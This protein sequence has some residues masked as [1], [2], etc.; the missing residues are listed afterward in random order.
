MQQIELKIETIEGIVKEKKYYDENSGYHIL[1][2][3]LPSNKKIIVTGKSPISVKI[4]DCIS[5]E[6]S[7][8][9]G[10][11][12]RQF[13]TKLID[14]IKPTKLATIKSYLTSGIIKG[15]TK[16]NA[17]ELINAW[18]EHSIEVID[19]HPER[20]L[21]LKGIGESKLQKIIDSWEDIKPTEQNV[22]ELMSYGF[23]EVESIKIIQKFG[24]DSIRILKETPY[25]IHK[26]IGYIEFEKVD[27]VALDMGEEKNSP[28]R[29]QAAIDYFLLKGHEG[30]ECIV[31]YLFF[32]SR[33]LRYLKID[34]EYLTEQID[35][36][37]A[38]QYFFDYEK[39]E[40]DYE[41]STDEE[42]VFIV[43][44]YIQHKKIK[45][46]ELEVSRRLYM[47]LN[48]TAHK[49]TPETV[50]KIKKL[51]RKGEKS[52]PLSEE[53]G[54]AVLKSIN[55]KVSIITGGPG[56]GKTTVL[57]DVLKQLRALGKSVY[58]CAPTGKAAQRMKESTGFA[59][60][61]IHRLL[62]F[63]PR[64]MR[65]RVNE[66]NPLETDVIVIDESS[67]I[68]IFLMMHL[69][70]AINNDTQIVIVGDVNQLASVQAGAV[71][72]D[73]ID[74][75][76]VATSSL[77]QI[78]RQAAESKIVT[79]AH[80]INKGVFD[81]SY[82]A[83][84]DEDFY[85]MNSY[86]DENTLKKMK[87]IINSK[88]SSKFKLNPKNDLQ[89]LVPQHKGVLGTLNLNKEMQTMLNETIS[90]NV[91]TENFLYK[92]ND[93]I[94]QIVNNYDKN[95]FNG[96][97]GT[98]TI[99]NERGVSVKFDNIVEEVEY[100]IKELEEISPSYCL[101]I[102]KSQGSEY[103]VVIIP[104]PQEYNGIIDRSLI[105]TGITRGKKLVVIIGN[106]DVLKKGIDSQSSRF[107]KTNLKETIVELFEANDLSE[108]I[109]E[110]EGIH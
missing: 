98:I 17:I 33:T 50:F 82:K 66:S 57:N 26:R 16:K 18:G 72:R 20:L 109:I 81:F 67:M 100:E 65:F 48:N 35:E 99:I 87:S 84:A 90:K 8:F 107:R 61:T 41:F 89:L 83:G 64:D 19:K 92:E 29:I 59:A 93:K 38:K 25:I 105:Y 24:E 45:N 97:C 28:A 43:T 22:H 101:S 52:F 46:A 3:L 60:S 68:D 37:L 95:V 73:F 88:I 23:D 13:G 75:G 39:K 42:Y 54:K 103:P 27:E 69:L 31:N 77:T 85:F 7:F 62:D 70:R 53:Q 21:R 71:L 106:K 51:T 94:I 110:F 6:G 11:R 102:H 30:G 79:N 47:L 104:L 1:N 5:V 36:G 86:S 4:N 10:K 96:D 63:N 15:L 12:G 2:V 91:K 76:V 74:S 32:F 56:T 9:M 55:A 40:I 108:N 80:A 44:R 58:L 14:I 49:P 34:Q 78:F